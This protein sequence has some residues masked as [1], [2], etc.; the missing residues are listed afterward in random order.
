ME[1]ELSKKS[2]VDHKFGVVDNSTECELE[3]KPENID[4]FYPPIDS[5][6]GKT[7]L[8]PMVRVGTLPF[9]LLA[10]D[11]GADIVYSEELIAYKLRQTKRVKNKI[12]NTIDFV[13]QKDDLSTRAIFRT[14]KSDH[15]NVVQIGAADSI[16]ALKAAEIVSRDVNGI[17]LNMGCPK[18]FSVQG[19][20][21]SALLTKPQTVKEI[22]STLKR[23]LNNS[24]TCKIRL[25]DTISETL[26]L[27]KLI[28][29]TGVS[30]IAIHARYPRER[31]QHPAHWD[32]LTELARAKLSV[33]LILN[34]DVLH[35][36]D[37]SKA[38]EKTSIPSV[39]IA[40]GAIMN[41]SIFRPLQAPVDDMIVKYLKKAIDL[42][43]HV[44]NTKYVLM[45]IM[46][47]QESRHLNNQL[48]QRA[49]DYETIC[50]GWGM[51]TF[52]SQ[53]MSLRS[54]AYSNQQ[55]KKARLILD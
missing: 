22:L 24:I 25:L 53:A 38:N 3:E 6:E 23:N 26:D 35:R 33:P 9:R 37:I 4:G 13:E 2:Q 45:Q 19:G 10:L 15:P 46:A 34:G 18:Y 28:E 47:Y 20:M 5:Y 21:G 39:M 12:S 51:E 50:S 40:R 27:L 55:F 41:P 8:A 1:K 49:T 43:N 16:V 32:Q 36:E 44:V 48:V 14:C 54:K 42:S 29:F 52:Y 30:A 31:P 7:I 17:D 11:E